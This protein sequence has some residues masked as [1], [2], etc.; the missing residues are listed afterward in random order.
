MTELKK[1]KLK[2]NDIKKVNKLLL[3][4]LEAY[5][6]TISFIYGDVPIGV[7]CLPPIIENTLI[8]HGCLRVYDLF[9]CDFTKIEGF[10]EARIR[11][12]TAR[13]NEFLPMG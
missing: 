2:K 12:L 3:E 6:K 13:L 5:R 7:L 9:D 10:G 11:Q 4:S 8:N 1:I